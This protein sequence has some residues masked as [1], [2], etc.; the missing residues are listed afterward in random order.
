[1]GGDKEVKANARIIA[2][3]HRNLETMIIQK[4]FRKDLFYRLNVIPIFVPPLRER[5]DELEGLI[6]SIL[7]KKEL[8]HKL[9][10]IQPEALEIL[11]SYRWPGNVCELE[12]IIEKAAI[13][14]DS[15][16][17]T[18]KSIPDYIQIQALGCVRIEMSYTGPLD[19]DVFKTEFEKRFIVEALRMNHGKINQTVVHANMPKNTLLRKIKKY[20]ID[21]AQYF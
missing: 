2:A 3:T 11:K 9:K 21:V 7:Q 17:I 1:M 14:E 10:G 13:F 6:Q 19:F 4:S 5:I 16:Y 8:S 18:L 15:D 20:N 12:N